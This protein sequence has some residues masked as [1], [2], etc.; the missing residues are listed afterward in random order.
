MPRHLLLGGGR[1]DQLTNYCYYSVTKKRVTEYTVANSLAAW[2]TFLTN[3]LANLKILGGTTPP[4]PH[5]H[6]PA[7]KAYLMQA[8]LITR[9][10][11]PRIRFDTLLV[12]SSVT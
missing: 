12:S 5:R 2:L 9:N 6:I 8:R 7:L 10:P 3:F 1:S 4:R 11:L